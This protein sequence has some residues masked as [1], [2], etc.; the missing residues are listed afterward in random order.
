MLRLDVTKACRTIH[1][2]AKFQFL[3]L[4]S[5]PGGE[6]GT[7]SFTPDE[8]ETNVGDIVLARRDMGTSYHLSV[9]LD[10]AA[11]GSPM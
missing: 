8:L 1:D 11:Q 6:T 10:D 5:G 4:G 7:I 2:P 3:E 9:V